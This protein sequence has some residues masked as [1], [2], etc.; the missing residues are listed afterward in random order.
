VTARRKRRTPAQRIAAREKRIATSMAARRHYDVLTATTTTYH[1]S[2]R[3]GPLNVG[4][5]AEVTTMSASRRLSAQVIAWRP[6]RAAAMNRASTEATTR[7][8]IT[9]L[10]EEA[11]RRG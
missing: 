4:F 6:T 8:I 3:P 5:F 11:R 10:T 7:A 9:Q 1:P 2:T